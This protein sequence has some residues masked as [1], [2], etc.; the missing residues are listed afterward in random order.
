MKFNYKDKTPKNDSIIDSKENTPEVKSPTETKIETFNPNTEIKLDIPSFGENNQEIKFVETETNTQPENV[1]NITKNLDITESKT[2]NKYDFE[3]ILDIPTNSVE[4]ASSFT[5]NEQTNNIVEDFSY[6]KTDVP[7]KEESLQAGNLQA[8]NTY[9]SFADFNSSFEK[10]DETKTNKNIFENKP[11]INFE[12]NN[13]KEE[14]S[15]NNI[16]IEKSSDINFDVEEKNI[17]KEEPALKE[18][19]PEDPFIQETS[20]NNILDIKDTTEKDINNNND[21]LLDEIIE[22]TDKP[23][24]KKNKPDKVK[25]EK[26]KKTF[27]LPFGKKSKKAELLDRLDEIT[28][29]NIEE[30]KPGMPNSIFN[31]L[32]ETVENNE[33]TL[34]EDNIKIEETS[35]QKNIPL[36]PFT[37]EVPEYKPNKDYDQFDIPDVLKENEMEPI[38]ISPLKIQETNNEPEIDITNANNQNDLSSTNN[39]SM[40][41]T[42]FPNIEENDI[43]ED[44]KQPKQK[45]K[46]KPLFIIIGLIVLIAILLIFVVVSLFSGDS[47]SKKSSIPSTSTTVVKN[48]EI[49]NETVNNLVEE[50]QEIID[51]A[52]STTEEFVQNNELPP[53]VGIDIDDEIIEENM[54][55]TTKTKTFANNSISFNYPK[56]WEEIS[57]FNT[58]ETDSNI[59]NIVMLGLTPLDAEDTN[60]MRITV[61]ETLTAMTAK[62]YVTQTENLMKQS[63]SNIKMRKSTELTIAGRE[64]PSRIYTFN[65]EAGNSVEQFQIY[66]A[67]GQNMYVITF[68]SAEESFVKNL[69]TYKEILKTIQIN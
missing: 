67:N 43:V 1:E 26:T 23:K 16:E 56:E 20:P 58:R 2:T 57:S 59:K 18:F 15:N 25:K 21:I 10:E 27:S 42:S 44:L 45:K 29:D 38:D 33:N 8:E 22:K 13:T 66:V 24:K 54:T 7:V 40:F 49:D 41:D 14:I 11:E 37:G 51:N 32:S 60:N 30:E 69:E 65:D 53:Q 17:L 39:V 35:Q 64:A 36:T 9:T 34:E 4:T 55:E 12:F 50:T 19:Q 46:I 31:V 63:F 28:Q 68:T 47:T 5:P 61:E 6:N 52:N 48:E 3:P 62:D